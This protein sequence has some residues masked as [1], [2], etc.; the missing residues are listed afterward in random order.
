MK[1]ILAIASLAL[2]ACG[3]TSTPGTAAHAEALRRAD[4]ALMR[5]LLPNSMARTS[6]RTQEEIDG[7]LAEFRDAADEFAKAPEASVRFLHG[8]V[9]GTTSRKD[10]GLALAALQI[11]YVLDSPAAS[12]VIRGARTHPNG[13]VARTARSIVEREEDLLWGFR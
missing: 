8:V 9:V 11:L 2:A 4:R 13:I 12:S 1:S 10:E 7:L 5:L 3:P 6:P